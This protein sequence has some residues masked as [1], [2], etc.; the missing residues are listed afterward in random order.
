MLPTLII[1][2]VTFV[3]VTLSIIFFPSIKIGKVRLDTYWMVA[4]LGAVILIATSLAP[5]NEVLN[6]LVAPNSINP[7]KILILFF[8]MTIL[9]IYLDEVGLF[10]YLACLAT[11]KAVKNQFG[12]FLVLYALTSVLTLF[13]SND[14]VILTLTPFICF[15]AKNAKINPLPFLIA[16]FAAANTW[17]MALIIGNPTNIYLATSA[18]ITFLGYLKVMIVPTLFA[19][20][21]EFSLILLIFHKQLHQPI[22]IENEEYRIESHSDLVLGVS[23]LVV[24]LVLL[25]VSNYVHFEMW[26][27]SA[28]CA[29]SLLLGAL[30]LRLVTKRHWNYLG[31]SFRRLPYPLIP[32][33]LSMFVIVVALHTQGISAALGEWLNRGNPIFVYGYASF[34]ASNVINNIPMSILFSSLPQ[35]LA[36][37]LYR[38]A[39]YASVIGSNIGAFL[40]P[41]GALAGIMFSSLLHKYEVKYTFLDFTKYGA[42]IALPTITVALLGLFLVL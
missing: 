17:S 31:D 28:A 33:M 8:S 29:V 7:L 20:L 11:K 16:E 12:L 18:G 23:L 42:M 27:V 41:I 37:P 2:I 14:V 5:M 1:S 4:L 40:T 34:L 24:C 22:R 32:F 9:S 35:G 36:E 13:T 39:V 10:R 26:I 3:L 19:G 30:I 6:Q 15:F 21:V 25:T 38:Q